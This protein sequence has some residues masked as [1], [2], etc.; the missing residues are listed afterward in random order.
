DMHFL[1]EGRPTV[2]RSAEYGVRSEQAT[3]ETE[4]ALAARMQQIMEA[5]RQ[6][7]KELQAKIENESDANYIPEQISDPVPEHDPFP[8]LVS[9]SIRDCL[10]KI[11]SQ[12]SVCSKEWVI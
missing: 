10:L 6:P 7:I 12:P 2:T 5:L 9:I 11:L 3:P 8:E 4:A 1:H